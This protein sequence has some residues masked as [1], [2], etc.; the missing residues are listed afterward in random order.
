MS[1]TTPQVNGARVAPHPLAENAS[2]IPPAKGLYAKLA[3]VTAEVGYVAKDGR[4]DF[5]NY[6]YTSAEALL[7]AIRGPLATRNIVLMP[8]LTALSEREYITSKGKASVITTAHVSFTL[9]DGDSG[10]RHECAW[11]GQ[12]DDPGDKGLGKAYTNAIKTFLREQ[13]LIP[14]GDDPEAD[15]ATD[16][17]TSERA[18]EIAGAPAAPGSQPVARAAAPSERP[19]SAKQRGL[20]N[21]RA[22]AGGLSAAQLADII[23]HAAGEQPGPW[24]ND[25]AAARWLARALDRLPARLVDDVLEGIAR[26]ANDTEAYR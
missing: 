5:Q 2:V 26:T 8:A 3:Q 24:V 4:N 10:E 25:D 18:S 19:C 20:I 13:F 11:A 21:A 22:G 12:G 1:S 14:Q 15:A 23:K 16:Q 6:R 7:A 9:V 17:R